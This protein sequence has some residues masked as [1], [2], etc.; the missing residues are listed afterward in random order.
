[1]K[2]LW[3]LTKKQKETLK[4]IDENKLTLAIGQGRSGKTL[5]I[6][7]LL[8]KRAIQYPGTNHAVFRNTLQ[9]CVDGIWK[10]T[11]PEVIKNFFPAL[12]LMNGW[13][14]NESSH[15]ITL[16]NGSRI[17]IKG[18]DNRD[19]ASKILST[20]FATIF[21][22]ESQLV[23]YEFIGLLL[24]R[25]PQ[26]LDVQYKTKIICAANWASK[27]SWLKLFFDDKLNPETKAPHN[28]KCE[29][30]T[31]TTYDN[32]SIDAKEYID[33]LN[34]AGDRKSRLMCAGSG[35]YEEI[36]G[37]LWEQND[38]K[39]IT[40]LNLDDYDDIIISFDP[41]VTNKKSS[42]EH[43][44]AVLAKLKDD[45]HILECFEKKEDIN[46]IVKEIIKLYKLYNCSKLVCE[47]NNGGDFIPALINNHAPDV[48]C[49]SVRATRGKLLRAEPVAALYKNGKVFHTKHFNK[50]E[51]QMVT[52][53]GTGDSPNALDALVWGV[54]YLHENVR[55]IS[56]ASVW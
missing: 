42:D 18:L 38:I 46:V 28:Q 10:I 39:R 44:V 13:K 3:K 22:D 8:F 21:I 35:F 48:Y 33:T 1:M 49:E 51:D 19:R 12:P 45:L 56:S 31:S 24:T 52:Y 34:S 55:Y 7:Y 5:A 16:F 37:A 26:P 27:T 17:I 4:I 2:K 25:L 11:I 29:I 47:V 6:M 15:E 41:A 23:Y 36:E 50:L 40:A 43:G 53:T 14:M 9:S 54:T 30:I 20:E 32:T